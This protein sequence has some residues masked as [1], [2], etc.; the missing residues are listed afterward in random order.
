MSPIFVCTASSGSP[1]VSAVIIATSVR[2]PVPMS[3]VAMRVTTLP[4][5]MISHDAR[6][7]ALPAPAQRFAAQPRPRLIG[8]AV[9][10]PVG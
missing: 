2:V 1:I 7:P 4:S 8:P 10:S 3:C 9:A 6:V 5:G